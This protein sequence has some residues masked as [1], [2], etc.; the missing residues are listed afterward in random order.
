MDIKVLIESVI[1]DLTEDSPISRIMLKAQAISFSLEVAEFS[2]WVQHEQNGYSKGIPIPDYR[3]CR[4]SAKV[5][6]TQ[7]F[8]HYSNLDVPIDAIPDKMAQEMLSF[9]YFSEP[10]SELEKMS[11]DASP[12]G[13]LTVVA[14][15]YAYK[16]A[17]AIFPMADIDMLWKVIN[18]SAASSIVEIVKSKMLSFFLELDKRAQL[19]VDFNQLEGRN[20]AKQV[21]SQTIYAGIYHSGG[22]DL[23]IT[24]SEIISKF[25]SPLTSKDLEIV[26]E[27]VSSLKESDEFLSNMDAKEELSVL[28]EEINKEKPSRKV[29]KKTLLFLKDVAIRTGAILSSQAITRALGIV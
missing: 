12:D 4:C 19:G 18:V 14:P 11:I 29:I 10:I 17:N 8:K 7:G 16:K 20:E 23:T 5:N 25:N 26:R 6:L 13:L 15:A 21:L 27:L 22:G 28:E 24:N 2:E 3:K 1:K 9:I